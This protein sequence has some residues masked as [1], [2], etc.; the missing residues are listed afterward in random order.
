MGKSALSASGSSGESRA[1]NSELPAPVV[2]AVAFIVLSH[3]SGSRANLCSIAR[4]SCAL[5]QEHHVLYRKDIMTEK[6][7][8]AT[9][10]GDRISGSAESVLSEPTHEKLEVGKRDLSPP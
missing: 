8:G 10:S 7:V 6:Q 3:P 1:D 2:P 9:E 5:S 4:T